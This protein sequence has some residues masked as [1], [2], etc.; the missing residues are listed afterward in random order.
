MQKKRVYV[1]LIISLLILI[2]GIFIV[3]A[4]VDKTTKGWHP[5]DDFLIEIDGFTMTLQE[6]ITNNLFIDGATADDT[7]S[8]SGINHAADEIWI[9]VDGTEDTLQNTLPGI[10]A[11]CGTTTSAY[12]ST[13]TPSV[14]HFANEIEVTIDS[15]T[16]SFQD[17]IDSGEFCCIPDC[18]CATNFCVGSTCIDSNCGTSCPG[19]QVPETCANLNYECGSW[20]DDGC[21]TTLECGTCTDSYC[22][23]GVCMG[24]CIPGET[25][26]KNCDNWDTLCRDYL[27]I[28]QTCSPTG[29]WQGTCDD[30]YTNAATGT[31]C[32]DGKVCVDGACICQSHNYAACYSDDVYWYDSCD[33]REEKKEDCGV[34]YAE[35]GTWYQV[36]S[37][38]TF[39]RFVKYYTATCSPDFFCYFDYNGVYE[40]EE[41]PLPDT[42]CVAT[43]CIVVYDNGGGF[44]CPFVYSYD[45]EKWNF[46][47]E[48]F[49]FSVIKSAETKTYD[50]LKYLKEVNGS[51][52]LRIQEDLT[53]VSFIDDFKFYLVDHEKE[54]FVMP[55]L[56]GSVHVI[57]NLEK[58]ISCFDKR[59]NDCLREVASVDSL[60]YKDDFSL[61]DIEDKSTYQDWI[62][63]DFEK[64]EDATSVKLFLNV[65]K[66]Q[67]VTDIYTFYLRSIGENYWNYWQNLLG[68]NLLSNLFKDMLNNAIDLR[69]EVW[70]GD[71]WVSHSY[72]KAG[73][74]TLDDFLLTLDISEVDS[75]SLK[76]RLI[77]TKGFY[78]IFYVAVDYSDDGEMKVSLIEPEYVVFNDEVDVG[79]KL[80]VEDKNYLS[81]E[82][83][84]Y[85][86]L[87][88]NLPVEH[89]DWQRDPYIS[90][91]G[92]YNYIGFGDQTLLGFTKGT[93]LWIDSLF[94]P[95]NI[96]R[97]FIL[98]REK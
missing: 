64:P 13:P 12:S 77:S 70:D 21:G 93:K 25:R 96:P 10:N 41:C 62:V 53:E 22:L 81:L 79:L 48:A 80:G 1:Y 36:G 83:G 87:K 59:N 63:L 8:I 28:V 29:F 49:V 50:R 91:K 92:Y 85:V 19:Q 60:F 37:G 16:I 6:A 89:K 35:Y 71:E 94:F 52:Y 4:A 23:N 45:G 5:A 75:E 38:C 66:Q 95:E 72:I 43:S 9:S 2:T 86:N 97:I 51:Y 84:D 54:G 90:I 39:Q 58:P 68:S 14:Y 57:Q 61:I 34:D 44:S 56:D 46:E 76:V 26:I 20:G 3:N 42:S 69:V 30:S 98:G 33:V 65:Q 7:I 32:G 31:D 55:S 18:S 88:Y 74:D 27:D 78:K 47:H 67:I 40:R 11:I 82:K 15:S 24:D 73:L 17:A